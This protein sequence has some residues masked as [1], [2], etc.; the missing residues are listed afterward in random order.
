M[1]EIP[2]LVA[3]MSLSVSTTPVELRFGL[4]NSVHLEIIMPIS[5]ALV[6]IVQE[7]SLLLAIPMV[8][9]VA[10]PV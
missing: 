4:N 2:M 1:P 6:P 10:T 3:M 9:S 8:L 5:M 7:M